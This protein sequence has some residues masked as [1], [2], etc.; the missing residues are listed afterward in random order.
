MAQET[1]HKN[2]PINCVKYV[3]S[4]FDCV[5]FANKSE[6]P[7]KAPIVHMIS[8]LD[9]DS[10]KISTPKMLIIRGLTLLTSDA[11]AAG[12]N[13]SPIKN[14]TIPIELN[15]SITNNDSL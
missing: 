5:L 2:M 9:I 1:I 11:L 6:I 3:V 15:I 10:L 8:R 13:L 7:I 12:M 4:T 14:H